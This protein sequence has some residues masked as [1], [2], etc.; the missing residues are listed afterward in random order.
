MNEMTWNTVAQWERLHASAP[1]GG[2]RLS[3]FIGRPHDLSPRA[4]L[5]VAMGHAPPFDR[6]DWFITRGSQE[7]RYII[8]FYFDES[9]A[10]RCA[11]CV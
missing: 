7:V 10:G 9:K 5:N 6:H 8:D 11:P 2:P 3:R 1:G 4:R